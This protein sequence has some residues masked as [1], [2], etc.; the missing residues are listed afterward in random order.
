MEVYSTHTEKAILYLLTEKVTAAWLG[1]E[2]EV[3]KFCL[4]VI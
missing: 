3:F 1:G 4:T 2:T